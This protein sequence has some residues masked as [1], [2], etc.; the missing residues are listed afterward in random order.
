MAHRP[1]GKTHYGV[2]GRCANGIDGM[3]NQLQNEDGYEKGW[4]GDRDSVTPPLRGTSARLIVVLPN[5]ASC[6]TFTDNTSFPSAFPVVLL[7]KIW[8]LAG[9]TLGR[10]AHHSE[11][12][13][14]TE[15]KINPLRL[16]SPRSHN[17]E[18]RGFSGPVDNALTK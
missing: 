6:G 3:D 13:W 2:D 17:M 1:G 9:F 10:Q 14:I 16:P 18:V 8:G 11:K 5:Y 4:H 12:C 15:R 7:G